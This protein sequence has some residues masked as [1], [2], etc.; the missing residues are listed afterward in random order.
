MSPSV[1]CPTIHLNFWPATFAYRLEFSSSPDSPCSASRIAWADK[2]SCLIISTTQPE[3]QQTSLQGKWKAEE[4]PEQVAPRWDQIFTQDPTP[5]ATDILPSS[6]S[7]SS[8]IPPLL[9]IPPST[10]VQVKTHLSPPLSCP[11][12][13]PPSPLPLPHDDPG[14]VEGME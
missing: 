12:I 3:S 4:S 2:V 14:P 8:L 6:S 10:S 1:R 5:A 9:D 11:L 13:F 7:S